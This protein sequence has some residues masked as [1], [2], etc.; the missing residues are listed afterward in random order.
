[1]SD[2]MKKELIKLFK[3]FIRL[4]NKL[5]DNNKMFKKNITI[6]TLNEG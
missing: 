4:F 6:L 5:L 1:M 2:K 3:L